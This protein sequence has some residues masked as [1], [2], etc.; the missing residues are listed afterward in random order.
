MRTPQ[1]AIDFSGPFFAPVTPCSDERIG[2]G[3]SL[4]GKRQPNERSTGKN[5][6]N[7]TANRW[8]SSRPLREV[9]ARKNRQRSALRHQVEALYTACSA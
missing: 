5:S 4:T 7:G 8:V 9:N 1:D 2:G 3:Q 6:A